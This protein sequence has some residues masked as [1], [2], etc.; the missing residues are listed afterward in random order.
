M[1]TGAPQNFT[2]RVEGSSL[3]FEWDPPLDDEIGGTLTSYTLSC[4]SANISDDFEIQLKDT[5]GTIQIDEFL[6]E[7]DYSCS[8]LASNNGGDGPTASVS[9]TT[10]GKHRKFLCSKVCREICCFQSHL[11]RISTS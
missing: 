10:E 4:S 9:V 2:V 8:I 7:T 11:K 1:P 6:P 3:I 5:A